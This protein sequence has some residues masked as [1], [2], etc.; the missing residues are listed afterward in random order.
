MPEFGTFA[1][2][3]DMARA[4]VVTTEYYGVGLR[5]IAVPKA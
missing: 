1:S 2:L 3:P 4:Q 5:A